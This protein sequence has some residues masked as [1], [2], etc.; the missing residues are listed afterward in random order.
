MKYVVIVNGK[1]ESGKTTFEGLCISHL[2]RSEVAHGHILSSIDFVKKIYELLGWDGVKTQQAR[3]HLS[4]LKKIWIETSN[5][6][7]N[8]VLH[9]VIEGFSEDED[10]VI[11]VDVREESEIIAM[12]EAF[13]PLQS[14][15][16]RCTTLFINRPDN[17]GIEYGN[18][19]DDSV[20]QNMS[21]YNYVINN[22]SGLIEFCEMAELFINDLIFGGTNK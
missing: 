6:P 19:S 14:H 3:K 8:Y 15:D 7:I 21:L 18:K 17:E 16:V 1:P 10:H 9:N 22:S 4:E 2:N 11:F 20:G 5:G 12:V 13:E